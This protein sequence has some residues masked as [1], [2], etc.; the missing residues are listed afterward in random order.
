MGSRRHIVESQLNLKFWQ[1]SPHQW[2]KF[3]C[4][5]GRRT[6][7]CC[8]ECNS[9][10]QFSIL[11]WKYFIVLSFSFVCRR[12]SS[13]DLSVLST[14]CIFYGSTRDCPGSFYKQSRT[15]RWERRNPTL[16][17]GSNLLQSRQSS[18]MTWS[19][20]NIPVVAPQQSWIKASKTPEPHDGDRFFLR[21]RD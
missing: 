20:T 7:E 13:T 5:T 14:G 3:T 15:W 2:V 6:S 11:G 8:A 10:G 19:V 9:V 17:W 4:T 12:S 18:P 16:E 1:R 21:G